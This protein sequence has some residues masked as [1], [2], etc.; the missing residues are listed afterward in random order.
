MRRSR[1]AA[2][3][4]LV[5]GAFMI[6]T[7]HP[8]AP[9]AA[10]SS[11]SFRSRR[12]ACSRLGAASDSALLASATLALQHAWPAAGDSEAWVDGSSLR[13][14][15]RSTTGGGLALEAAEPSVAFAVA[16]LDADRWTRLRLTIA[17]GSARTTYLDGERVSGTSVSVGRGRHLLMVAV[18]VGPG[19]P[20]SL[21]ASAESETP[22]TSLSF[23]VEP[24]HHASLAE[25]M[26]TTDVNSIAIAP[27]GGRVA[28]IARRADPVND[29]FT[30]TLEIHDA[31]SGKLLRQ[32]LGPGISAPR[33]SREG[34]ELAAETATDVKGGEGRD[35]WIWNAAT[36]ENRRV[37]R[38]VRG[39]GPVD[40]SPDGR[41]IYYTASVHIGAPE[42]YKP[43]DLQLLT[44]VWDRSTFLPERAQL[45]AL[46]VQQGTRVQLLGDTLISAEGAT[47]SPDGRQIVFARG[48]RDDSSP[49]WLRAE[50]WV[51]DLSDRRVRKLYSICR[52]RPS[53][54]PPRSPGRPTARPS[55][56]AP[57]PRSCTESAADLQRVRDGTVRHHARPPVARAL[58]RRIHPRRGVQQAPALER[59]R[60]PAVRDRGRGCENRPGPDVGP[61]PQFA[62]RAAAPRNHRHARRQHHRVR[63]R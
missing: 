49:P 47:L 60:R 9:P 37:L 22:G 11:G 35:L 59:R 26:A 2:R 55:P 10:P 33:W 28:W 31:A 29:G 25:L 16:Y 56:S 27:A 1:A 42:S 51:L 4:R 45:F 24:R 23:G 38:N 12:R 8:A 21:S 5:A 50:L 13:W 20:T 61:A 41:W 62:R 46:D 15:A 43:G 14:A 32:I 3:T 48:V 44:Q 63:F 34:T 57:A 19:A 36:G 18:V 40:W 7:L 6:A 39:L 17:G 52:A 30:T 54:P 58:E 53:A